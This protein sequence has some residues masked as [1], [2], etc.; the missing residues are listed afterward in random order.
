MDGWEREGSAGSAWPTFELA[1]G[2][3][4]REHGL[5]RQWRAEDRQAC[6]QRW[7]SHGALQENGGPI[8]SRAQVE[9]ICRTVAPRCNPVFGKALEDIAQRIHTAREAA[10]K[11]RTLDRL[12]GDGSFAAWIRGREPGA[13]G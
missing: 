10:E 8:A 2:A 4:C 1:W 13:E 3:A 7:L 9:A 12:V 11:E 5:A 6:W